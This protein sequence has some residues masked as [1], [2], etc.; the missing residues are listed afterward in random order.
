MTS[1]VALY[2]R[3]L[4]LALML[5]VA[6]APNVQAQGM[7]FQ[8]VQK[9]GRIYV[10]NSAREHAAWSK[11]GELGKAIARLGYGDAGET[12]VFDSEAAISLFNFKHGREAEAFPEPARPRMEVFWKDGK[13][14]VATDRAQLLMS[15]RIQGRF[16]QE[17]PDNSVKLFS[18]AAGG[19]PR[20]SF[21]IRRAKFKL[22]GWF[23]KPE[24]SYE[25]QINFM[26]ATSAQPTRMI[27]DASINWDLSRRKIL[28]VRFGQ[29]KVPFGRQELTSSGSQQFVDRSDVS[30][31]YARGRETGVQLWG[32]LL[33]NKAEWRV[34]AFNGEGRSQAANAND[35]FQYNARVQFHPN[36]DPKFSESDLESR[37]KLLW[38]IAANLELNDKTKTTTSTD[39]KD[40]ILGGDFMAKY[41]GFSL[42]GEYFDK[43]AEPET[44]AEFKDRGWYV[45]TGYLLG[46]KR[47]WEL[48]VRH[49]R[50]DPSDQKPGDDRKEIG[51]AVNYYYNKHNVKLQADF[52]QLEDEAGNSGK[53]IKSREFRLQTQFIF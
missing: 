29:F 45:Q 41:R 11:S 52:R 8:E 27:E 16:T 3:A 34:G 2:G 53:G 6:A 48:A 43:K 15:T 32:G 7:F 36:G 18:E 14:S 39:T 10:F 51:G 37:D 23:Y 20:S 49:G 9:D 5:A 33:G 22:E 46:A 12:V 50:I 21:R 4:G 47:N 17:S 31:R 24:L 35:K 26:D 42:Q 40:T 13:T 38:A 19:D 44:G 25:F 28:Q 1:R 30:T